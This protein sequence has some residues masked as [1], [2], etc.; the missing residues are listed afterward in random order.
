M[1]Y[2]LFLGGSNIDYFFNNKYIR[3]FYFKG[4]SVYL[5]LRREVVEIL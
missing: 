5:F 1:N 2:V 4:E 3:K